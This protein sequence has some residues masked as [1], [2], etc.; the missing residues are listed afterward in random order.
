MAIEIFFGAFPNIIEAVLLSGR[1]YWN[2]QVLKCRQMK[3]P[4]K[5]IKAETKDQKKPKGSE[6]ENETSAK[7]AKKITTSKKK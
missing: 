2:N 7:D 6:P 1:I 3:T 4:K 5:T